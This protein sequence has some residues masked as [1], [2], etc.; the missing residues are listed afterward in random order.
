VEEDVKLVEVGLAVP[1]Q[2]DEA[3]PDSDLLGALHQYAADFYQ[4]QGLEEVCTRNFD[5]TAL[6]AMGNRLKTLVDS[7]CH[8]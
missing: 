3:L 8:C 6:L 4:K 5:E 7:R 2:R 1:S